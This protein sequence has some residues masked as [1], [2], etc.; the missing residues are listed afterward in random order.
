MEKIDRIIQIIRE[1]MVANAP[2]SQGGFGGS[3]DPKG[4]TAGFDPVVGRKGKKYMKG[5]RKQWL[6]YLSSNGR[7][8]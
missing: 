2:G 4:P 6:D 3:A 5:K 1:N 7:R 8:N